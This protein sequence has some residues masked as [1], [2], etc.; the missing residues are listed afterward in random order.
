MRIRILTLNV[1]NLEGDARRQQVIN[2]ELRRLAPDL[3]S[4][5]EVV[6]DDTVDQ[7]GA[8]LE[9]TGLIG[10]HQRDVLGYEMPWAS[11]F[12]GTAFAARWPHRVVE[13]IDHRDDP[14]II[15]PWTTLGVV[16]EV[17][18]EGEVLFVAT[19][20]NASL[21][22]EVQREREIVAIA[23]LVARHGRELPT[24]LAGD[25]N[26][27][28]DSSTVRFLTGRQSLGGMSAYFHN[29]WDVAGTG[30]GYTW[31]A[32]NPLAGRLMD[33]IIRQPGGLRLRIDHVFVGSVQ[34]GRH[35]SASCRI[36]AATLAFDQPVD[37]LWPSDHFGVLVDVD[38]ARD[39][40]AE[41]ALGRLLDPAGHGF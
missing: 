14:E 41:A 29:A 7:L 1:L 6:K 34:V 4:L 19:T 38:L 39:P 24:I 25:F 37:G 5:Q 9:G 3:V 35:T 12:G 20:L 2:A 26:A 21:A 11:R 33:V 28:P 13:V 27:T 30:P 8:L 15:Q 16:V 32:E 17:P 10:S 23:Q 40:E 31:D 18:D 22:G 36:E